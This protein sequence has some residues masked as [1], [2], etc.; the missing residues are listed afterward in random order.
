ME[1]QDSL[2]MDV[3][4]NLY[5]SVDKGRRETKIFSNNE[6]LNTSMIE[7]TGN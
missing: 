3:S 6:S 4:V 7:G 1:P 2:L 5:N